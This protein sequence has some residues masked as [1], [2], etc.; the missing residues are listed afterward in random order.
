MATK[1]TK[2]QQAAQPEMS[3]DELVEG[4]YVV[5]E[6]YQEGFEPE[7]GEVRLEE[8]YIYPITGLPYVEDGEQIGFTLLVPNPDFDESK[9]PNAKTNPENLQLEAMPEELRPA[10]NEEVAGF[11]G[12]DSQEYADLL[13][14]GEEEAAPAPE[15]APAPAKKTAAKKTAA[16]PA[17]A[18]AAEEPAAAPAKGKA[19][20]KT[21]AKKTAAAK[22]EAAPEPE[23]PV[24]NKAAATGKRQT[25]AQRKA[26]EAA[27]AAQAEAEAAAEA[28]AKAPA[29]ADDAEALEYEDE[30]VLRLVGESTDLV[31]TAQ[32]LEGDIARN[33]WVLGGILHHIQIN[34]T[35]LDPSVEGYETYAEKGG[36]AKFITEHMNCDYR[37][38]MYLISIYREFNKAGIEN[39]AE[40][41]ATMGWTKAAKIAPELTKEDA[42]V[43]DLIE[44]ALGNTVKDLSAAI[45]ESTTTVGGEQVK[46]TTIRFRLQD[47]EAEIVTDALAIARDQIG[48]ES[49]DE[50]LVHIV[51]EWLT[52]QTGEVEEAEAAAQPAKTAPGRKAGTKASVKA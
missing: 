27:A 35:Y 30:E 28:A 23:K 18:E 12:E 21:A 11:Y 36:F 47:A 1:Q 19:A 26:E 41:V 20:A 51:T 33:E 10:T 16:K 14:A 5:F 43:D 2:Q 34:K 15:P 37:K 49:P 32:G 48:L 4:S 3:L 31:G 24:A 40:V 9:R 29:T 13:A 8:G 39:G 6:G 42:N 46:R 38:A 44:L 17:A 25:A 52:A 22:E 50:A 45:S 7:E